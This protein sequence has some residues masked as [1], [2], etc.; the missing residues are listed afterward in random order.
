[1]NRTTITA[2]G[3]AAY[4]GALPAHA[5]LIT[6]DDV[7]AVPVCEDES[8]FSCT[9]PTLTNQYA[10]LGVIFG[11]GAA[12]VGAATP[13]DGNALS[14]WWGPGLSIQFTGALPTFVSMEISTLFEQSA[15]VEI[16]GTGSYLTT[17]V[18]DGWRGTEE[19]STPYQPKQ[20]VSFAG[21]EI[22]TLN[23]GEFYG[24]RGTMTLDNLRFE[25]AP[26]DVPEPPML[27]LLLGAAGW[28]FWRRR[29]PA[30]A[31]RH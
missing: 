14:D 31:A 27:G 4:V 23:I 2:L 25:Y 12:V 8:G 20:L 19:N 30:G 18:T 6:F 21:A 9:P 3:V 22:A 17:L 7:S 1:M 11:G 24:R 26:V 5:T 16:F 29:G 15:Y 13:A 28:M 10:S